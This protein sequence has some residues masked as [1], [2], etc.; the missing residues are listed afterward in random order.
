MGG[1][2]HEDGGSTV[3]GVLARG[4]TAGPGAGREHHRVS[5]G[6]QRRDIVGRGRLQITDDSFGAGFLHVGD[7]GRVPDQRDGLIAALSQEAL[8]QER[9]LPVPA[10]DHY[11]HAV[12]L[13]TELIARSDDAPGSN[14]A[15]LHTGDTGNL[16]EIAQV[17]GSIT[18]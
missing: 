5:P 8:Q 15:F 1:V 14:V 3:D 16:F 9:D 12:S 10:R 18:G 2:G 17:A 7:V 6:Q 4:T 11:A 13:L